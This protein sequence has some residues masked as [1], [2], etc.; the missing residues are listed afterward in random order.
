MRSTEGIGILVNDEYVWEVQR[1]LCRH[2]GIYVEPAGAV[3]VAGLVRAVSDDSLRPQGPTVCILTGHGF[4]D[5]ASAERMASDASTPL[6][7]ADDIESVV[8]S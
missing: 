1:D 2:E 5:P 6:I 4:K 3:A 8:R 7:N